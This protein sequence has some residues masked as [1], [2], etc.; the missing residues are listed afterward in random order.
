MQPDDPDFSQNADHT[1]LRPIPGGRRSRSSSGG[2]HHAAGRRAAGHSSMTSIPF[3][4]SGLNRLVEAAGTLLALM[5]QLRGT[6]SHPDIDTLRAHVEQEVKAFETA[7]RSAGADTETVS[8]ARYVLC[9]AIDETVLATPW[10]NE[11]IWSEQTLLATFHREAWGG[12]KFFNI[13]EYL[14]QEP[15]RHI[16]LLELVY[17]CIV[18][19]FEGKYRVQ[20]QGERK[21]QSI[22][23]NLFHTI[24][25][26][27]GEFERDLSPNWRGVEDRRNPLVR[28]VPFWVL[29]TVLV[30]LLVTI[31]IGFRT[32][33]NRATDPVFQQ[34]SAVGRDNVPRMSVQSTPATGVLPEQPG[35][36][37]SVSPAPVKSTGLAQLLAPEISKGMLAVD[38]MQDKSLLIIRGDGVFRSGSATVQEL[39]YPLLVRIG[40]ALR[41]VPGRVMVVGHTD[42]VPIRSLRFR[43]NWDLSRERAVSVADLLAGTTG[44]RGRYFAEGRADTEP[45][46]PN[47]SA[48][49]RA[50]NRRVEVVV[51][52]GT[53]DL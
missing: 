8:T 46:V 34:L 50:R 10:G 39:Y 3:R 53:G 44:D 40:E 42:N 51:F 28:Y 18:M 49:N 20:E 17:L 38:E 32:G 13:L 26:I 11:S 48:V 6:T 31:F 1:V 7:A 29:G 52:K 41:Q 43:S 24:R 16:D 25:E 23:E 35:A 19:G 27:R 37:V 45:L 21:L 15:A 30:L 33:L 4:G 47:D 22:E 12:E 14:L 5:G 36:G 9:T 2:D